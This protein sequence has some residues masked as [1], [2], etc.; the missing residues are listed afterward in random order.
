MKKTLF[1][2][3]AMSSL[4]FTSCSEKFEIAA[5]YK[6]ITVVYGYLDMADTAHYIR[7]QKAFLDENKS[8]VAMAQTADS[9]FFSD[10]SVRIE[11]Y[12]AASVNGVHRYFDSIHLNRV[13]LAQEGYVKESGVFF[14]APNYA[15]KF[16][17]ALDSQYIYRL[18]ITHLS[19]G[20]VD[21]ADAPII[22][23]RTPSFQVSVID[24]PNVVLEGMS[25]FSVLP[26]R[27]FDITGIYVP[28]PGYDYAGR[29]NPVA[30][31]Q[32]TIRFNWDD[33]DILSK[34]RTSHYYDF[35]AGYQAFKGNTFEFSVENRDLY[36]ALAQGMGAAPAN[37]IR[38]INKCNIT[39]HITTN[40]FADYRNSVQVQGNGL[41]GSEISPIYTN[42]KGND[43]LGLYTSRAMHTGKITITDRTIDSL[44]ASPLLT[45]TNLKGKAY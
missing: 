9:S 27:N 1:S 12:R 41:T 39:V 19:T 14:T 36:N 40:D 26:K 28:L 13:D 6:D 32:A 3:L 22:N 45:H 37:T 38:L 2:L 24:D 7:I 42:I 30:L 5:P 8:A 21:S 29:V 18:K 35:D 25:F 4:F 10:I 20:I 11:R 15:Y 17:D 34:T 33:S 16:T 23:N 44:I 31:A 43:V